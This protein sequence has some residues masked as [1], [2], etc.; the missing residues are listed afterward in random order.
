MY[1]IVL[2]SFYSLF[3]TLDI[4]KD[5]GFFGKSVSFKSFLFEHKLRIY[6][7]VIIAIIDIVMIFVNGLDESI[8][9][10]VLILVYFGFVALNVFVVKEFERTDSV[11]EE[12]KSVELTAG[13]AMSKNKEGDSKIERSLSFGS[14]DNNLNE[15]GAQTTESHN[16]DKTQDTESNVADADAKTIAQPNETDV[17]SSV[18]LDIAYDNM[19]R[20]TSTDS[21]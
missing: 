5:E 9:N 4:L 3:C 21:P 11:N 8:A 2:S 15:G 10:L 12:A 13:V 20:A 14:S 19:N 6:L 1:L 16:N 18:K 7:S 17:P